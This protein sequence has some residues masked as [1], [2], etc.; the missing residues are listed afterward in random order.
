MPVS[1]AL[2]FFWSGFARIRAGAHWASSCRIAKLQ[3]MRSRVYGFSWRKSESGVYRLVNRK[4]R[5]D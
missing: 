1:L 3:Q 2:A 5:G 4:C